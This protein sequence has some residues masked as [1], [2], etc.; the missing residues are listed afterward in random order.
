[1]RN[2]TPYDYSNEF[3][4]NIIK[5]IWNLIVKSPEFDNDYYLYRFVDNDDYLKHL[6]VGDIYE[7]N[8]FMSTTR[9]PFY[10]SDTY[11]FGFILLKIKIPK[12]I[13]G[14][15]L[16]LETLS[17]FPAEQEIILPPRCNLKLVA[18]N[19]NC[20]YH[21]IDQNYGNKIKVRYEFEWIENKSIKFTRKQNKKKGDIYGDKQEEIINFLELKDN[22]TL[23]LREKA[24]IFASKYINE[25]GYF[26]A[27][28]GNKTFQLIGEWYNS[29]GAY[30]DFYSLQTSSGFSIYTIF[31][32]HI[33]FMIELADINEDRRMNVNYYLR[34]TNINRNKIIAENDFMLFLASIANYFNI[35]RV[36]IY[37]D[38]IS[39]DN[40]KSV[41][42]INT[43]DRT[44]IQRNFSSKPLDIDTITVMK[45]D[46]NKKESNKKEDYLISY[47]GGY[48][49][50][51]VYNYLKYGKIRFN[52]IKLTKSELTPMYNLI[53]L[54]KLKNNSPIKV[55]MKED[56]DEL[57]QI[58]IRNYHPNFK[59]NDTIA[60]FYIWIIDNYCYLISTLI[61]K[62][63]RL[64]KIDNPFENITYILI[65]DVYLYNR[66]FI[67]FINN[68]MINNYVLKKTYE[69]S[70]TNYRDV[71][72][73]VK[74]IALF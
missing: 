70:I 26:K 57:Y 6:K 34:Y 51:D 19:N 36:V 20:T 64:F 47:Y 53:E 1:M 45:K 27:N 62:F 43:T 59:K 4:E 65:P 9:D 56:N 38:F 49:S 21:H 24:K 68:D 60:E 67:K 15:G 29:I 48:H 8:G 46:N 42:S 12:N 37:S 31:E 40:V 16:C 66:K 18:K 28:I 5:D 14:V 10:K 39:C 25:M 69:D 3:L 50:L 72:D 58:Y 11:K 30:S 71:I 7:E 23:S 55:L 33:L 52:D 74:K 2:L 32:G 73:K 35:P 41:K 13:K 22:K 44:K 54:D 61:A 63:S 17:Q